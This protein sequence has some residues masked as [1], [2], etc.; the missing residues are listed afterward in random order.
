MRR[1][2]FAWILTA[3]LA[4]GGPDVPRARSP[5]D[6]APAPQPTGELR[7]YRIDSARSTVTAIASATLGRYSLRIER[8][9]GEVLW[10]LERPEQSRVEI[11]A[12]MRSIVGTVGAVTRIVKS[13]DFLAV[14][15]F[16][17]ARF[18]SVSL[19]ADGVGSGRVRGVL[20]LRGVTRPIEVPGQFGFQGDRLMLATE[21]VIDRRDFGI[22]NDGWLDAL[23]HDDV[24]VRLHLVAIRERTPVRGA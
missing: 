9:E 11:R 4:C 22:E 24:V 10:S 21:F 8:F 18:E 13:D 16:P 6:V 19:V 2:L 23:V 12:D 15:R 3:P 1:A 7:R 5:D 20:E 14:E 17:R